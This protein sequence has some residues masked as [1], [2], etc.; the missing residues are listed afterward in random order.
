[1]RI[2]ALT[3]LYP[4]PRQPHRAPFNRHQ[5]RLLN[6]LSPLRV[7]A[8]V[9]WTLKCPRRV[10]LDGLIVEHPPFWYP[11]RLLRWHGQSYR[12]SVQSTFKRAVAEFKPD[13]VFA[14]WAY[15]DGWAAVKLARE[16]NLPVVV[17][18]HG[19]DVKLLD[20][21]PA[22]RSKTI[23]TLTE[24]DGV[25][26]V[27]QDLAKDV[28]KFGA[29]NVKMIYDGVDAT[30][31]HPTVAKAKVN[32]VLFIG[33]LVPVK[34]VDLLIQAMAGVGAKLT[35]IGDGPLRKALQS[36]A[37][38]WNVDVEFLGSIPQA[39]LPK[40]YRAADLFV[41]PSRSEG[42]PN[43]LLEASACGVPWVASDVGG[44][45]EIAHLGASRLVPPSDVS[46][47]HMAIV[48]MLSDPPPQPDVKPRL[49]TDAVKE[50]HQYLQSF[51]SQSPPV[52]T[53]GLAAP[54]SVE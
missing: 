30:L 46:A 9:S 53:A 12:W 47:L 2:L 26:A 34:S 51:A 50:L 31:F 45:P 15:P 20:D 13:I 27:S 43:V 10:E 44:I 42:V 4:N 18:V 11:P 5:F 41:L 40:H 37:A 14:P 7:I 54:H 21:Y 28:A 38:S 8:P 19:S 35:V 36:D 1:M 16:H 3:N 52:A 49:R 33:N 6:E 22:K 24:A 23:E 25:V 32:R 17:Q 39:D 29:K 48:E